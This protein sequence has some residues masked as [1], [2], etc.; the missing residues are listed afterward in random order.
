M[1][2]DIF[3]SKAS[4][5]FDYEI[6]DGA[7]LMSYLGFAGECLMTKKDARRVRHP[8]YWFSAALVA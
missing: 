1:T 7:Y 6:I 8:T 4:A 5:S 3:G 2:A